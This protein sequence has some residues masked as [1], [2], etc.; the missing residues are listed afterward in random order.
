MYESYITKGGNQNDNIPD[1][2]RKPTKKLRTKHKRQHRQNPRHMRILWPSLPTNGRPRRSQQSLLP[3]LRTSQIRRTRKEVQPM[4]FKKK[5]P[6][7]IGFTPVQKDFIL[8]LSVHNDISQAEVVRR[9][10]E[11]YIR[12]PQHINLKPPQ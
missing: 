7:V 10:I 11:G 12:N 2:H 6:L 3:L 8:E 1:Y 4:A 9:I 5:N